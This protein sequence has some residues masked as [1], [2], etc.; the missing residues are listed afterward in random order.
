M[1]P[2]RLAMFTAVLATCSAL[3]ACG[4]VDYDNAPRGEF[5]GNLFVMWVGEGGAS[6]DGKFLFVPDPGNPLSFTLPGN[7][8]KPLRIQPQMMYTDGGSIPKIGQVFNGFG[9]W[10]YA[11]AYMIHDWLY[12]ARHCN[13]DGMPTGAEAGMAA[14]SFQQSADILASAIRALVA[15]GRVKENDVAGRTISGAVAGPIARELWDKRGACP[16]PRVAEVDRLA[17]EAAIP[18]SSQRRAARRA[19]VPAAMVVGQ[20]GF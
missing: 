9:P 4:H 18:G 6:G 14:I 7:D 8:G 2:P 1:R 16:Q 3:S 5:S 13:L 15:S 17:A 12:V 10:G 19:G 20:F 11:P